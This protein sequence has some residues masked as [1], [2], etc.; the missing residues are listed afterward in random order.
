M[1]KALWLIMVF[2]LLYSAAANSQSMHFSQ[3]YNAPL[4][5]N[6]ANT[7]LMPDNDYRFGLNYR[8]QWAAIPVPYNTFSAF[9]D[10]KIGG[11]KNNENHNNWLGLGLAFFN[12]K[13]GDGNLSLIQVQGDIA[14]HLQLSSHTMLSLGL[15]G[16][17]VQRSVNYDNLLFDAQWDGATFNTNIGNGEKVGIIKTNYYTIGSG[18]NFAWFPNENV[19]VKLGGSLE[20]I[21][22]PV[23]S[24]YKSDNTIDYRPI[25]DLDMLFQTGPSLIVNPSVYYTT[26]SGASE[27]VFGSQ[28][29]TVLS[30]KDQMPT[31]LILGMYYRL[32]DAMIGVAG[33]QVGSVQFMASYDFTLSGLAP[34]NDSYGALEF[35]LIYSRPYH[36]DQGIKKMFS[37]PRFF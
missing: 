33:I 24:F 34:Y 17:L 13:A 4:L 10:C 37:C 7:A 6:P 2:V 18:V 25:G 11:N 30:G 8:N 32:G 3:Y 35:S 36:P 31:Q 9:G 28:F 27:L 26:Q 23:E 16:A 14:Y 19:Y 12:D 22:R 20:N 21:N 15:S 5:L 29:R 1:K